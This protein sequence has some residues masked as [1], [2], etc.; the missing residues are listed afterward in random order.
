MVDQELN[1]REHPGVGAYRIVTIQTTSAVLC[2]LS[3]SLILH[4]SLARI[5][6]PC[7][8]WTKTARHEYGMDVDFLE[9]HR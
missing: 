2:P 1:E 8:H 4:D 5:I 7:D 3:N 6:M 9:R